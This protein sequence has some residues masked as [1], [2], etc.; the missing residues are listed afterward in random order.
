ML[1][2]FKS[3]LVLFVAKC[4]Q[5]FDCIDGSDEANCTCEDGQHNCDCYTKNPVTCKTHTFRNFRGCYSTNQSKIEQCSPNIT[6]NRTVRCR[7]CNVII[8]RFKS[9]FDC[10]SLN[11]SQLC[12]SNTCY[13][14]KS[15]DCFQQNCTSTEVICTSECSDSS[16]TIGFQCDDRSLALKSQ[17]C[18]GK[19]DC[20]DRSDEIRYKPGFKCI[21]SRGTCVLPQPNLYDNTSHCTDKSDLCLNDESCFRCIGDQIIV[22]SKQLCNG[23]FDCFD[24]SDECLCENP[25]PNIKQTCEQ[26]FYD[27]DRVC[28][29]SNTTDISEKVVKSYPETIKCQTKLADQIDAAL[30]DGNPECNDLS[31]ECG[32]KCKNKALFCRD[33]CHSF[34]TI[35]EYY[36]D[37]EYSPVHQNISGCGCSSGFDERFCSKRY[38]CPAGDKVSIRSDQK[39]NGVFDCDDRSDERNCPKK[40]ETVFSSDTEM[41]KF[42]SLKSCFWIVGL[43]VIVGNVYVI[44]STLHYIRKTKNLSTSLKFQHLNILNI[45]I[46]DFIMSFYLI[47]IAI[48]STFVY[49][50]NYGEVDRKWRTSHSCSFLGSLAVLS[51]EAS[52]FHMVLLTFY[53]L[54]NVYKP[55]STLSSPSFIWKVGLVLAWLA[56]AVLAFI[57]MI[58]VTG[59]YFEENIFFFNRFTTTTTGNKTFIT[60]FACRL[61]TI[62]KILIPGQGEN[63]QSVKTFLDNRFPEYL[64]FEEGYYGATSVCMPRFFVTRSESAMEYTLIMIS[65]NFV[66]FIFIAISYIAIYILSNKRLKIRARNNQAAKQEATMQRR[67]ARIIFTDF[68]CWIPICIM[69][70]A[71][72]NGVTIDNIIY[73]VSAAILLPINSAFN[74]LLYSSLVDKLIACCSKKHQK[75]VQN[76]PMKKVK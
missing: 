21:E 46:A 44:M 24:A 6:L 63:W 64:A 70:Y 9:N 50:G 26:M 61:A 42:D 43:A 48:L 16:C 74:P 17:F 49:S 8:S 4:D 14:T 59:S 19:F 18:D 28:E 38:A 15:E 75:R 3:F 27:F 41:I 65:I 54:R 12:D 76:I 23:I 29:N 31:D 22:S 53:R 2:I 35:G 52:C 47:T 62:R 37:G 40:A 1:L 25:N 57:P 20:P 34:F 33:N 39:C 10:Q 11:N 66:C 51:S 72:V 7:N 60:K 55:F 68:L 32:Q 36:C 67:I 58:G 45:S 71:K 13:Q 69:V 5:R 56:A 30:C 73:I